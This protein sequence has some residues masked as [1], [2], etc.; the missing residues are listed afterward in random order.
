MSGFMP[1]V[2][3]NLMNNAT[4]LQLQSILQQNLPV[5]MPQQQQN[6]SPPQPTKKKVG[7][8]RPKGSSSALNTTIAGSNT[9][10]VY[11]KIFGLVSQQ[12]VESG[13]NTSVIPSLS[14]PSIPLSAPTLQSQLSIDSQQSLPPGSQQLIPAQPSVSSTGKRG[15]PPGQKNKPK[16]EK[17]AKQTPK[18]EYDFNS[19]DEHSSEPMTY[20]EKRQLSLDI[21]SLTADKL[22]T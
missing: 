1:G 4:A 5:F 10:I 21:N 13:V 12:Q 17:V 2:S 9:L 19:E 7:P 14:H 6:I 11:L 16:T 3:Q 20:D 22:S 15:R 8:G 18:K